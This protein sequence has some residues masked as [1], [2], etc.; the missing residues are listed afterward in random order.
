MNTKSKILLM[1]LTGALLP[2]CKKNTNEQGLAANQVEHKLAHAVVIGNSTYI[3]R[4]ED[5]KSSTTNN[6]Q[7]F[8]HG[9]D[10]WLKVYRN[11]LFAFD[12]T[13]N[14]ITKY[15]KS[16][17]SGLIQTGRLLFAPAQI[18]DMAF[19][20]DSKAYV[21]Y[22]NQGKIA[23]LNPTSMHIEKIIDLSA[24]AIGAQDGDKNP[25][26]VSMKI[27][28]GKL[29]VSLYQEKVTGPQTSSGIPHEHAA[30]LLVINTKTDQIIEIIK[31]SRGPA[32]VGNPL[33]ADDS[34]LIDE[35]ENIYV[36]CH[37]GYGYLPNG[38][39]TDGFLRIKKSQSLFDPSY[40]FSTNNKPITDVPE[41]AIKYIFRK[42]YIGDGKFICMAMIPGLAKNKATIDFIHDRT[43]QTLEIDVRN[44]TIK[45][46]NIPP[47]TGYAC[48]LGKYGNTI[49]LGLNTTGGIGYYTYHIKTGEVSGGPIVNIQGTPTSIVEF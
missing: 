5:I 15:E 10:C 35:H 24:Y 46:L 21:S 26:P 20:N 6:Q 7:A 44:Q 18:H 16:G 23:I 14:S 27:S 22:R 32:F 34:I 43:F 37:S 30:F 42:I 2:S 40:L 38:P 33:Y 19:L 17:P 41:N 25:E 8:E 4:I 13:K 9:K 1:L 11:R 31:D 12:A 3:S 36:Y 39:K 48:S 49:L 47:T 29:Y 28:Q 45:K